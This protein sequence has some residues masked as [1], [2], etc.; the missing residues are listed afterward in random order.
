MQKNTQEAGLRNRRWALTTKAGKKPTIQEVQ[1]C[2]NT[3]VQ[4]ESEVQTSYN[5][6]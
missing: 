3:N 1:M 2:L 6:S 4:T 5:E